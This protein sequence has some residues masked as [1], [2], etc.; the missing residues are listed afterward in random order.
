MTFFLIACFTLLNG[1]DDVSLLCVSLHMHAEAYMF[2]SVRV[3]VENYRR[4]T[5]DISIIDC[6]VTK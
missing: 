5:F 6:R 4:R 2:L 1:V 3:I